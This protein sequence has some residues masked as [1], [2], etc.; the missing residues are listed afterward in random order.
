MENRPFS[1]R[2]FEGTPLFSLIKRAQT[3]QAG[4][5]CIPAQLPHAKWAALGQG[6]RS[7]TSGS[8]ALTQ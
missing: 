1:V 7:E 8:L 5:L 6:S 3:D 4:M 2:K